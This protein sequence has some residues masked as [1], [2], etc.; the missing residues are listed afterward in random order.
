MATGGR[1]DAARL[2][3]LKLQL[4]NLIDYGRTSQQLTAEGQR[5]VKSIRAELNQVLRTVDPDYAK[6]NDVVSR[7][8]DAFDNLRQSAGTKVDI[9][10]DT[11]DKAVGQQLRRLFSNTQARVNLEDTVKLLDDLADELGGSFNTNAYDLALFANN[12]DR[13]F[14]AV[15]ETSIQGVM[16]AAQMA[17]NVARADVPGMAAQGAR[18]VKDKISKARGIDEFNAYRALEAI[19]NR[20]AGK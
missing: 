17:S 11:A 6:A 2:H 13:K 16:E 7:G 4:D 15:A 18:F 10:A 19:L 20:G 8:L 5:T 12:L 1:P 3:N 9:F 14:G